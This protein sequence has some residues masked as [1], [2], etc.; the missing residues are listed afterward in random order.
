MNTKNILTSYYRPKPGGYC[1][2]YFRAINALLEQGAVVHYLAVEQ[3]PVKHKNCIFHHFPWPKNKTENM[4]FWLCFHIIAPFMLLYIGYRQKITHAFAFG[5][6]YAFLMQPLRIMKKLPLS[7]FL[8]GDAITGHRIKGKSQWI[9]K[10]DQFFE[11]FAIQ[12]VCLYGVSD[13]LTQTIIKRHKYFRPAKSSTLRNNMEPGQTLKK[14]QAELPLIIACVGILEKTK[15]QQTL[16]K[17]LKSIPK[18]LTRLYLYGTGLD[19]DELIE[20]GNALEVNDQVEFK[21]W[22]DADSIWPEID[23]LAMPSLYEGAPNAVLEALSHGVPVLAS[24]IPAHAEIL[25]PES[26]LPVN[27]VDAWTNKIMEF[28]NNTGS[29]GKLQQEQQAHSNFLIFNWDDKV[30]NLILEVGK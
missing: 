11:G 30:S 3:Y 6:T 23:L 20:L 29:L 19:K 13:S 27:F 17:C 8:R 15:N 14:S 1:K 22:V 2:R 10:L 12:G 21:G 28:V 25:P 26:L 9:I 24:D 18:G 5:T 7:V 4:V 16:F